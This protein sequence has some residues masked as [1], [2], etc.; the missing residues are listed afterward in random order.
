MKF[1]GASHSLDCFY[2]NVSDS[3][4]PTSARPVAYEVT[5]SEHYIEV[6]SCVIQGAL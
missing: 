2:I 1:S 4:C 5:T 3:T 6:K